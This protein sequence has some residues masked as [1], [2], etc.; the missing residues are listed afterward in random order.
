MARQKKELTENDKEERRIEKEKIKKAAEK[1][2]ETLSDS[3]REAVLK[4]GKMSRTSK[5]DLRTPEEK[6]LDEA[7]ESAMEGLITNKDGKI[8][9][10]AK[11]PFKKGFNAG[12]TYQK[13]L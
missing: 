6:E 9:P 7:A 8:Q 1:V 5:E 10:W 4:Y 12:V 2:L 13:E 3:E 11:S